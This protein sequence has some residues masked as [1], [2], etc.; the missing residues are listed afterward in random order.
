M[1]LEFFS[2]GL[3]EA[4]TILAKRYLVKLLGKVLANVD[5]GICAFPVLLAPKRLLKNN[6][7]CLHSRP[8]I[9]ESP[10][11][12]TGSV[13]DK[14]V[15]VPALSLQAIMHHYRVQV[16]WRLFL[17]NKDCIKLFRQLLQLLLQLL[18]PTLS[19]GFKGT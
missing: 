14:R 7:I 1:Q 16:V 8:V 10:P 6:I 4:R 3:G 18:L 12:L 13:I 15:V 19:L 5:E 17:L 9:I 11:Y 2:K